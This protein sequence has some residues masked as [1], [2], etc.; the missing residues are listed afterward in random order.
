MLI[1]LSPSWHRLYRDRW[2]LNSDVVVDF[3]L[4]TQAMLDQRD[5]TGKAALHH[6]VAD[7]EERHRVVQALLA[8]KAQ[9]TQPHKWVRGLYRVLVVL[10][11]TTRSRNFLFL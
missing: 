8:A 5:F 7:M 11:A 4:A 2:C 9:V 3:P 10:H 1:K 6:A